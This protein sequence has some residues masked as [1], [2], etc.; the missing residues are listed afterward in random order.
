MEEENIKKEIEEII[1]ET[2][3]NDSALVRNL[4]YSFHN[5]LTMLL[6]SKYLDETSSSKEHKEKIKK[7]VLDNWKEHT[8]KAILEGMEG[9]LGKS[10]EALKAIK[11]LFDSSDIKDSEGLLNV[12]G[13][14]LDKDE[15]LKSVR[16][17]VTI[18]AGQIRK[19]LDKV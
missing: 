19:I 18:A 3:T 13:S 5:T 1:G 11:G 15:M 16:G 14:A 6:F 2:G 7:E 10:Q 17:S 9:Y 8:E 4:I 12:F